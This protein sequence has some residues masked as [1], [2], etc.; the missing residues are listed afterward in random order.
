MPEIE[1]PTSAGTAT[2]YLATPAGGS[3][4]ATVVLQEWWGVE[5]HIRSV[6]DRLAKEGFF[7]LAPDLYGGE[8]TTQPSEAE[9]KMM[10]LSMEKVEPQMCGAADFLGSQEGA[11]GSGVG[12]LGFCLGGGLSVWA[13]ASCPRIT[14]AVTYYYVMPHGKPDFSDVKGPVLGHFGTADEFIPHDDAKALE[15]ELSDAGVDVTFHYYDDAGHAF[16]NEIDRLGTY[17]A[18]AAQLSWQR[19]VSFLREALA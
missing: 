15:S 10:A 19:T 9:Q 4:P 5:E 18:E 3:G 6:C 1:F 7:A 16:F 2:G 12:S 13:A 8:T 17:D 11:T 14:A